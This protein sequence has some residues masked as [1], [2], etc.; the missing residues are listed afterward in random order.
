MVGVPATVDIAR[1]RML[2]KLIGDTAKPF[3]A[4]ALFD[5]D[6]VWGLLERNAV[7]ELSGIGQR[8]ASRLQPY[9]I[10][11]CLDFAFAERLLIREL[12][13]RTGEA[14]WYELNDDPV[15]P[16]HTARPPH[17]VLLRGGSLG[18]KTADPDR[19]H[20]WLVRNVE[21]LVEELEFH[22]V[23]AQSAVGKCPA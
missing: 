20:A 8:R 2:A 13:T 21:R 3:G 18:G 10:T 22:V 19:L 12:L 23:C 4:L 5:R 7:T 11:T 17:K 6:A 1:T 14:I 15:I 9:G 16:L